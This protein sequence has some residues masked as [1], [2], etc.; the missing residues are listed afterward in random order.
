MIRVLLID[1]DEQA[2]QI[3]RVVLP[4]EYTIVSSL[5]GRRGIELVRSTAPDLVLLD[6]SLP[7]MHG[8]EVLDTITSDPVAPPVV[9]ITAFGKISLAVRSIRAGACNF[10]VKPYKKRELLEAIRVAVGMS[11][12][13]RDGIEENPILARFTGDSAGARRVRELL[14]LYAPSDKPILIMGESGT[15]KDLAAEI[16]HQIS[17]RNEGPFIPRNCA[18]IPSTLIETELFGSERGAFTDAVSRPGCFERADAG[19]LFLDEIGEMPTELQAKLLRVLEEGRVARIGGSKNVRI[20]VRIV[21]ATNADISH[22]IEHKRFR[23]D[24]YYRISTLVITIPPLRNR[25]EDI[26]LLAHSLLQRE[27]CNARISENAMDKLCGYHWP[28]N[29]R[30]LSNVLSRAVLLARRGTIE[31]P[32]IVLD[33]ND[34]TPLS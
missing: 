14:G 23:K 30:E 24:L 26:P 18:A 2:H 11:L 21:S 27:R 3:L 9:V 12:V 20:D 32:H 10:L 7:D 22:E 19:T 5:R 6:M 34:A 15:G 33:P 16:V 29:V 4:S 17:R 8:L 28:G 1:D 25:C 31:A 13:E